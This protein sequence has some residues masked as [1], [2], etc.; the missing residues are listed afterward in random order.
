MGD[1]GT[2]LAVQWL[3]LHTSNAGGMSSIPDQG[4]K[5]HMACSQINREMGHISENIP[6]IFSVLFQKIFGVLLLVLK[7]ILNKEKILASF[8]RMSTYYSKIYVIIQQSIRHL[9]LV[10]D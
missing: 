8:I 5:N 1:G 7:L 10:I 2:S 9:F 6:P 3:I 4:T